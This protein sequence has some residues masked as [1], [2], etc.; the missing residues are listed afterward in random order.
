MSGAVRARGHRAGAVTGRHAHWRHVVAAS[1]GVCAGWGAAWP[2]SAIVRVAAAAA[3]GRRRRRWRHL[4]PRNR[5]LHL[6][7]L[8]LQLVVL[9]VRHHLV[10][11]CCVVV[12]HETETA[13][14]PSF[15]VLHHDSIDDV[16][17][18]GEVRSD[19]VVGAVLRQAAYEDLVCDTGWAARSR[20]RRTTTASTLAAAALANGLLHAD[21]L[22]IDDVMLI[23]G[24]VR[25]LRRLEGHEAKAALTHHHSVR[26]GAKLVEVPTERIVRGCRQ[27]APD[28]EFARHNGLSRKWGVGLRVTRPTPQNCWT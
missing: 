12:L 17:I 21:L 10:D 9:V 20:G 19:L 24:R 15:P 7:P 3:P 8:P 28:E 25:R 14:A 23:D 26:D 27:D 4:V 16:A 18:R 1:T 6:D 11:R 2:I 13:R 22:P 5:A